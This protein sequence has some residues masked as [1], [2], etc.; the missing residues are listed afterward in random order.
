[1]AEKQLKQRG[2]ALDIS[3]IGYRN[4]L[5]PRPHHLTF[6]VIGQKP[7]M[8][9]LNGNRLLSPRRHHVM[10]GQE[11]V[12]LHN[13]TVILDLGVKSVFFVSLGVQI[14]SFFMKEY[15]G[16]MEQRSGHVILT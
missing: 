3:H 16:I 8:K 9:I 5:D 15:D 7:I 11:C 1:M 10:T 12:I 13:I 14:W 6:F 4:L 2:K